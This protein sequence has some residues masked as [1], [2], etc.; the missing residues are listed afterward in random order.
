[1]TE[2][3]CLIFGHVQGVLFRTYAQ[4]VATELGLVG[5]VRNLKDR[6]VEVVA[7]GDPDTLK[8]FVE[9]LYEGSS[10]SK[11]ESITVDWRSPR[12]TYEEFSVLH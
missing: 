3:Y 7:Q 2:I 1:M 8:E 4:D 12:V 9:Y 5:S 10:L 6:T 11:V